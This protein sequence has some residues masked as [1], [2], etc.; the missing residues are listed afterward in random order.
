MVT[1]ARTLLTDPDLILLDE[2]SEGLAPVIVDQMAAMIREMQAAGLTILL[3]E[4]N[5]RFASK[6]S[7]RACVL[8]G[9]EIKYSGAMQDFVS[10]RSLYQRYLAV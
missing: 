10:D 1:I 5:M 8:E 2:P 6:I 3:S 7:Q 4:Q 9:G